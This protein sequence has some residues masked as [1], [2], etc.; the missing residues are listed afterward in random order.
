MNLLLNE[1]LRT[2]VHYDRTDAGIPVYVWRRRDFYS[3][4]VSIVYRI[5]SPGVSRFNPSFLLPQD[6]CARG[7][8][9]SV[10][11]TPYFSAVSLT[12][13]R[14]FDDAF[15]EF[16]D[17]LQSAA[18]K[19]QLFSANDAAIAVAGN[20]DTDAAFRAVSM[21]R[22]S[23]DS[24]RTFETSDDGAN[25]I[26]PI[27]RAGESRALAAIAITLGSEYARII[28]PEPV[29][30]TEYFE[31]FHVHS[32]NPAVS[33]FC[34]GT[35]EERIFNEAKLLLRRRMIA[36]IDRLSTI[37]IAAKWRILSFDALGFPELLDRIKPD[38]IHEIL[39]TDMHG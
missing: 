33:Q 27:F 4:R 26:I 15:L 24:I 29:V 1:A 9:T 2:Q 13:V 32:N 17:A 30:I 10:E 35:I 6:S 14:S 8:K 12:A 37:D 31:S 20:V 5:G 23:A 34:S 36:S 38:S 11:Q 18:E 16:M 28:N 7:I 22:P 25:I 21:F 39:W 19:Y 3:K